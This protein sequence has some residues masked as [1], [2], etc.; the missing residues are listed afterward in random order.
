MAGLGRRMPWTCAAFTVGAF[1]MI[2]VPP[3]A[4]FV[5]KWQLGLG[6]L[7]SDHA[8]VMGIFVTSALLNS[9]YFL[10]LVYSMWFAEP[11]GASTPAGDQARRAEAPL[12]LLV[13]AVLTAGASLLVGIIA[14]APYSPMGMATF[15]AE[16]VF[17]S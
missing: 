3:V 5:S 17:P 10:P 4:G 1:G 8:W 11:P 2:G 7:D 12:A 9:A 16:G 6:A 13:P 15:I 14:A